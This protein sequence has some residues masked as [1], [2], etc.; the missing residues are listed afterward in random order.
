MDILSEPESMM[1]VIGSQRIWC[2]SQSLLQELWGGASG[3]G[4]RASG[5]GVR[6]SGYGV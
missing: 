2:Q 6:A 4:V 1:A 3:Y 5:Y